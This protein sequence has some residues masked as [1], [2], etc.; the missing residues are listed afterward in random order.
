MT[1]FLD[2]TD[3]DTETPLMLRLD[4]VESVREHEDGGSHIWMA[5]RDYRVR[6]VIDHLRNEIRRAAL[7][8]ENMNR[9]RAASLNGRK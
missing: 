8:I 6:E 7:L 5:G 4:L 1:P 3:Y 9:R 2:L